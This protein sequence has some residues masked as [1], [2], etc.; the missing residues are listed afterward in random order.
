MPPL[1]EEQRAEIAQHD[2]ANLMRYGGCVFLA[3]L[4]V[5]VLFLVESL[6]KDFPFGD[7]KEPY[8][9]GATLPYTPEEYKAGKFE[10]VQQFFNKQLT[11]FEKLRKLVKTENTEADSRVEAHKIALI[12]KLGIREVKHRRIGKSQRIVCNIYIG[13]WRLEGYNYVYSDV[14]LGE[15]DGIFRALKGNWYYE[16]W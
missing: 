14:K 10:E 16:E 8:D 12:K 1:T 5:L 4:P 9:L 3:F 15:K 7:P 6:L 2:K 11:K 13:D